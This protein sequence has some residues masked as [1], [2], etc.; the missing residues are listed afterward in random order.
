MLTRA[1]P[2]EVA[3]NASDPECWNVERVLDDDGAVEMAVF[4][5]PNAE[6]R[7]RGYALWMNGTEA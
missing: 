3:R 2:Y 6:D 7:A 1:E 4:S 5:G